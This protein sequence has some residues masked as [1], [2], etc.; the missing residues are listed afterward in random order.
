MANLDMS[1]IVELLYRSDRPAHY[2]G[3]R[4]APPEDAESPLKFGDFVWANI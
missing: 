3:A 4:F 1:L 2:T